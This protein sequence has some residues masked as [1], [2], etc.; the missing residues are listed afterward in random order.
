MIKRLEQTR[1]TIS[2]SEVFVIRKSQ[3]ITLADCP[4]CE[5]QTE[6]LTAEQVVTLTGISLLHI[7]KLVEERQL[8]FRETSQGHLLICLESLRGSLEKLEKAKS[9]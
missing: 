1:I 5:R 6:M 8:H 9:S 4:Q 2:K 7:F 3:G